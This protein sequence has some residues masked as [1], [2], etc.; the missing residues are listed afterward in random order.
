MSI[1]AAAILP[2][3]PLLLPGL[4][5]EVKSQV[6]KTT[7]A[8]AE[9]GHE[10]YARQIDVVFFL[11]APGQGN[12]LPNQFSL[13]PG[14]VLAYSFREFGDLKTVGEIQIDIGLTHKIKERCE[15]RLLM[16]LITV[17][18]LSYTFAVPWA[19]LSQFLLGKKI[20]CLQIPQSANF[21]DMSW[22][23][24]TVKEVIDNQPVRV[25]LIAAGDLAHYTP[26][27]D[28][29]SR[30]FDQSYIKAIKLGAIDKLL[31][32]DIELRERARECLVNPTIF[33]HTLLRA[34]LLP[35]E[36]LSYAN[37]LGTGMVVAH[38]P[39]NS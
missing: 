15:S 9:L 11:A 29:N 1:V 34:H 21:D 23:A 35:A 7:R 17:K 13:L 10:L 27:T 22:L 5:Q 28:S 31:N 12:D 20:V 33:L 14:A 26:T 25:A 8:I 38:L 2:H 30:I 3:S 6:T 18:Q 4:N 24:E 39:V 16:P 37:N 32:L 36:V 19:L